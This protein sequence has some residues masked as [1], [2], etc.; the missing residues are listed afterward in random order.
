L[1]DRVAALA[2]KAERLRGEGRLQQA[3][4]TWDRAYALD[5]DHVQFASQRLQVLD[6][7]AM[8]RFGLRFRYVPRGTFLMGSQNGEPDEQPVHPVLVD[9]FWMSET[10]ISWGDYC[11]LMGQ[12]APLDGLQNLD[13]TAFY[14]TYKLRLQY[15]EDETLHAVDWHCHA[16]YFRHHFPDPPRHH[17]ELPYTYCR[18]PI[19]AISIDEVEELC[20]RLSD[21]EFTVRL[22]TEAEWEKAARGGLTG[23]SFAWGNQPP[24]P[25]NCDFQ[26]YDEFSIKPSRTFP[27]NGYG[28]FAMCGSVWE[29]TATSYDAQAYRSGTT[30][31]EAKE[32]VLRGGSWT[33]CAS[34]VTVSFR[35][36]RPGDR[37]DYRHITA[38]IGF[39]LCL[40]RRRINPQGL[41]ENLT[42]SK[43][44]TSR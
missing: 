30:P 35:F 9:E 1:I 28:L 44:P 14:E 43:P 33:D 25:E 24:T 31:T 40:S 16:P 13:S 11:R 36:S 7:L 27:P 38:N 5:P 18:K 23:Q 15:C 42:D 39:R 22:P 21:S 41:E 37:T 8:D 29:W 10:T 20:A 6:A 2:A 26:R 19:I 17:H 12:G 3:A 4:T 32:R 34:A